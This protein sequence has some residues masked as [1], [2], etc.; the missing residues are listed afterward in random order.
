MS[1]DIMARLCALGHHAGLDCGDLVIRELAE[2]WEV[3]A[4]SL[5]QPM[6]EVRGIGATVLRTGPIPLGLIGI[7]IGQHLGDS[8]LV[9][10]Y[11]PLPAEGVSGF[12]Q[13][14]DNG[15]MPETTSTDAARPA[16]G[17]L[18]VMTDMLLSHS[19]CY[20]LGESGASSI[21]D[22]GFYGGLDV[23]VGSARR[24]SRTEA[25]AA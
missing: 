17:G 9:R 8:A 18:G 14:G 6:A 15:A 2:G 19:Y 5:H 1:S 25:P 11:L 4:D 12:D 10:R 22:R 24:G 16:A 21:C 3:G 23:G 7:D 13:V 20:D